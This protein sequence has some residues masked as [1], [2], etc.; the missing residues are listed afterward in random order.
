MGEKQIAIELLGHGV[1]LV[2]GSQGIAV[3]RLREGKVVFAGGLGDGAINLKTAVKSVGERQ[4]A[5]SM[6]L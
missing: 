1:L 5:V 3:L 4:G 6:A 2:L